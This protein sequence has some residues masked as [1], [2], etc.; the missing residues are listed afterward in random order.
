M[1]DAF[2]AGLDESRFARGWEDALADG[3]TLVGLNEDGLVD[4]F[5]TVGGARD[6]D[7]PASGQ[8][9]VLN[10]HPEA[11]GS[12][13]AVALHSAAL[14]RLVEEGN[15][16]AYLWVARDNPRARRFYEREGWITDGGLQDET[17]GG[18][19]VPELRYVRVLD[20]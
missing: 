4:G 9:W 15:A 1:P 13:L 19:P 5:A 2:L 17:F 6:A 8:L 20:T 12:G 3:T 7:P 16:A 14:A 10:V 11:F 18:V